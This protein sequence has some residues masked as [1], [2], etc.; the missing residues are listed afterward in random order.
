[1]KPR[2][3]IRGGKVDRNPV[4]DYKRIAKK[5]VA[6]FAYL[7][8]LKENKKDEETKTPFLLLE[9]VK[10]AIWEAGK[11]SLVIFPELNLG[12][13]CT[14]KIDEA[15]ELLES[16]YIVIDL[17]PNGEVFVPLTTLGVTCE[18][19]RIT[20]TLQ[21]IEPTFKLSAQSFQIL[22][23]LESLALETFILLL[24]ETDIKAG[25]L[26]VF[27]G[28]EPE[29]SKWKLIKR[30]SSVFYLEDGTSIFLVNGELFRNLLE[31]K[32]V[33]GLLDFP[34]GEALLE[35]L[36][37]F[38]GARPFSGE[39][40]ELFRVIDSP[41]SRKIPPRI[42][43]IPGIP[44]KKV[45][46]SQLKASFVT[47]EDLEEGEEVTDE[48]ERKLIWNSIRKK[49]SFDSPAIRK[50]DILVPI[51]RHS[52]LNAAFVCG[53]V[54]GLKE[55]IFVTK[56]DV[57]VVRL[58][59]EKFSTKEVENFSKLLMAEFR[60]FRRSGKFTTKTLN[61]NILRN[62]VGELVSDELFRRLLK[63]D[64]I[65]KLMEEGRKVVRNK[66]VK[67]LKASSPKA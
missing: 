24:E 39:T 42:D 54:P 1:M 11:K 19:L 26:V 25:V 17:E 36:V 9:A 63:E 18:Y 49:P 10:E 21:S 65:G 23:E 27:G 50:N 64:N 48:D 38:T 13:T 2:A 46:M 67:Y 55:R 44:M 61:V 28:C 57:A 16:P 35:N 29:T 34:P 47:L 3:S 7:D 33:R 40:L 12:G 45:G 37:A 6:L 22:Q 66:L 14:I 60:S 62:V 30:A 53:E 8:S 20:E 56:A 59:P 5:V 51:K 4:S 41:L 52:N 32:S 43:S 31:A 58:N 15:L